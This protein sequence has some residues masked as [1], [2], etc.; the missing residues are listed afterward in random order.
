MCPRGRVVLR[1]VKVRSLVYTSSRGWTCGRLP[2]AAVI[3]ANVLV[4][5]SPGPL[6]RVLS[7]LGA[8]LR[9]LE[10]GHCRSA[11][12]GLAGPRR[13]PPGPVAPWPRGSLSQNRGAGLAPPSPRGCPD[14]RAAWRPGAARLSR[15][16]AE[17]PRFFQTHKQNLVR[18]HFDFI[19]ART[20]ERVRAGAREGNQLCCG[21]AAAGVQAPAG[22]EGRW[23]SCWETT[24]GLDQLSLPL[25]A[26]EDSGPFVSSPAHGT[27]IVLLSWVSL[28]PRGGARPAP[29]TRSPRRES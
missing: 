27:L 5:T 18:C 13:S 22:G 28:P 3:P 14:F 21:C 10:A 1:R 17:L 25:A 7:Y 23:P 2:F 12:C 16:R 20:G 9:R 19:L 6:P 11:P 26:C 29:R 24:P 15:A 8:G 4:Y